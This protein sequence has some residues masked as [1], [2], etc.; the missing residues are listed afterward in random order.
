MR[1]EFG[2]Q[3]CGD[4]DQGSTR[5]WLVPDGLGGFAMGT[6][7]GLR[8]RR[9]HG[10]L[11]V[12]DPS[13][14]R[15][16]ALASL[17]PVVD[18][19]RLGT[20]EWADGT[21][22]PRGHAYLERFELVNGL[23]AWQWRLGPTVIRRELATKH[24]SACVAVVDRLLAGGPVDYTLE[25]LCVWR[26]QHGEQPP[27][28]YDD[29]MRNLRLRGPN[30]TPD[31]TW[32]RGVRYRVEAARGYTATEDVLLSGR[33]HARLERAGDAL[34][35]TCWAG[36]LSLAE[37]PP[38]PVI[39]ERAHR[40]NAG[41]T[42]L[43]RAADA[44]IVKGPEVV[45]GY[46]WFGA[47]S[48]DTMTSYEGL[49]LA[50]GRHDEGR[51][52]LLNY[53]ATLSEGMLVNTAGEFNTAD[54]TL[55]FVNAID[56]HVTLTGDTD[57]LA[58]L[59]P[60][61][62]G[63]LKAHLHGTRYGI[64]VDPTD[65]LLIQGAPGEALTWMDARV[66]GVP[67]TPRAGK[68]VEI[69]A[70]WCNALAVL[71]DPLLDKAAGS[72]QRMFSD[73]RDTADDISLRPNQLLAYSLPQVFL[74]GPLDRF[75]PLLTPL[76][77]RSLAPSDP[78]YKGRHDGT[79]RERDLAYHQGTVWPWLIGPYATA[80]KK[81]GG[82]LDGLFDGLMAHLGEWGLGSVSET[83]HGDAP[84]GATGCPFQAW[85]VA[86]LLRCQSL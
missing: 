30:W 82:S 28:S 60:A 66:E 14:S 78:L 86:E 38:A 52:L 54:A 39:I 11:V 19:V 32:M 25:A 42:A 17:D 57:L 20:H 61:L 47:W 79:M 84:H 73:G 44:F 5:E 81:A 49:F 21:I 29:V 43:Q 48:R 68:A 12:A 72:F 37:P 34:E 46:P 4:L 58:T 2:S 83:C 41:F 9:Y 10:L 3:L 18:G 8:T 71:G 64:R 45:A 85:S 36:D 27:A 23:P 77:L 22:A 75:D 70:L 16:V 1:I 13:L 67:V 63:I 74:T 40:R 31:G 59:R 15:K 7:S 35:V 80:L 76:G 26:D 55:W 69:N 24:G 51:E 33:F 56:R 65:G 62:D 53:A 6:V 50:T